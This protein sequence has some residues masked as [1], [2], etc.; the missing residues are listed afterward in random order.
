MIILKSLLKRVGYFVIIFI[1]IVAI[2]IM[3]YVASTTT[4]LAT[5]NYDSSL[6]REVGYLDDMDYDLRVPGEILTVEVYNDYEIACLTSFGGIFV[7]GN[8]GRIR[9]LVEIDDRASLL[10]EI[11]SYKDK[12]KERQV[13]VLEDN[14]LLSDKEKKLY[15]K[16][17]DR[18]DKRLP[19]YVDVNREPKWLQVL[20]N[21]TGIDKSLM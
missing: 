1:S 15:Q 9:Y 19:T 4:F 10:K 21:I 11:A 6:G 7:N 3:T 2:Y 5:S 8:E 12:A 14:Q 13:V 20:R 18:V 17:L 16:L